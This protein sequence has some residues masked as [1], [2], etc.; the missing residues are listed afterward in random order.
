[1]TILDGKALAEKVLQ[2]V[3]LRAK[4]F[5]PAISLAVILVGNDPA[6]QAYVRQKRLAAARVGFAFHLA[7]LPQKTPKQT[8]LAAIQKLN[9]DPKLDG[10]LVQLPLP[11][12]IN[13]A[14]ILATIAPQKDVD[15]FTPQ[16]FGQGFLGLPSLLPATPLGILHLLE[17]AQIPLQGQHVVIISNSTIVGRPLAMLL[18]ARNA[19][20]TVCHK[21]TQNLAKITRQADILISATGVPNLITSSMLKKD[22]IAIDVGCTKFQGKLVGDFNFQSCAQKA[23]LITPV[24]GGVGPMTVVSLL[25]NTLQARINKVGRSAK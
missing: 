3:Q 20:V 25:A 6:S 7:H 2:K 10:F 17:S 13:P 12:Q 9:R 21:F 11:K 15:G 23:R 22:V 14:A 18:M 19:T 1:M 16:N 8:L 5:S 24:P 4:K